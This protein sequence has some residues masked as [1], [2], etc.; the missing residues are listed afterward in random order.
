MAVTALA[1]LP[2]GDVPGVHCAAVAVLA[3][4]V[5]QAGALAALLVAL[6]LVWG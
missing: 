5:G 2:A 3:D 4:H 6:A 1:A